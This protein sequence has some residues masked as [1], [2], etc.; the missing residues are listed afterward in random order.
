[1]LSGKLKTGDRLLPERDP[2][3]SIY[4]MVEWYRRQRMIERGVLD[5][6]E[7][8]FRQVSLDG[9]LGFLGRERLPF[10]ARPQVAVVVA[11]GEIIDG[12]QPP[13]TVGGR[14][15]TEL[16]RDARTDE[17]VKA[18]VLRVDSP[19]GGV[20]PSEQIRR[21]V[22]RIK[23]TGKP[24]VV[25]MANVAASGGYWISMNADAIYAN[26][27]TITGSIGI[28]G[29]F[30]T[31]PDTLA[32]IGVRTD[33]VGTTTLA[34][35]ID[36]R[37]PLRPMV[38]DIVQAIIDDGY[39][40]FVG[41]VADARGQ[42]V[43]QIDAVARG[44]V[45]SGAQ[46]KERGLVDA[47]GGVQAAIADA[48]KRAGLEEDKYGVHYL[49]RQLSPFEQF[50][51]ST[52]DNALAAAAIDRLGLAAVVLGRDGVATLARDLALLRS[53]NGRPFRAAAFCFCEL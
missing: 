2:H 33:G 50:L 11:Q 15:T 14:S 32:K 26:E 12:E 27:S 20:F 22:A 37:M 42:S 52:S 21:E 29:L 53:P 13:G 51:V 1:M 28:F 9:Y 44:R 40:E 49:E 34:G 23:E 8:T 39:E 24:V 45:W 31:V 25:S 17:N 36:P 16:L 6:E 38:A 46:A 47:F 5:E 10:D 41:K 48:A 19:G 35:A 4:E 43:E 7:E 3:E 30:F 18:V